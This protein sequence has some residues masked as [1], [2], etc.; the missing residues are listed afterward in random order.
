MGKQQNIIFRDEHVAFVR[1]IPSGV[2]YWNYWEM[3]EKPD[4][5]IVVG[6]GNRIQAVYRKVRLIKPSL[7]AECYFPDKSAWDIYEP[8]SLE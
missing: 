5:V 4:C 2:E 6:E 1:P 8:V 3:E 7:K